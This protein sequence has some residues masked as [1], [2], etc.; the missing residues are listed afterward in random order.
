[1]KDMNQTNSSR[2]EE[3]INERKAKIQEDG[4][5]WADDRDANIGQYKLGRAVERA[6]R[7]EL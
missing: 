5:E 1:M 4:V 6:V 3:E 2:I 7:E